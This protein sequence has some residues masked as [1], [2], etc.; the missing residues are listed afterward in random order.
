MSDQQ[1]E[2]KLLFAEHVD[3]LLDDNVII[4]S[5]TKTTSETFRPSAYTTLADLLNNI[6]ARLTPAQITKSIYFY[7]R[8]LYDQ[9]LGFTIK[10]V[11]VKLLIHL[12]ES[13]IRLIQS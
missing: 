13:I 9:T 6:H 2:L 11:S 3:K 5:N 10:T 4:G 8:I 1:G 12:A 7:I